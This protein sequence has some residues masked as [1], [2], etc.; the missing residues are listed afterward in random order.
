M[1]NMD[2]NWIMYPLIYFCNVLFGISDVEV[3]EA[4]K[5]PCILHMD[6]IKGSHTGLKNLVQRYLELTSL[7]RYQY[8]WKEKR[9]KSTEISNKLLFANRL[10]LIFDCAW[11]VI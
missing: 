1:M 8:K 9:N 5:L 6:S 3:T 10:I 2:F 11:N 7:L 4:A